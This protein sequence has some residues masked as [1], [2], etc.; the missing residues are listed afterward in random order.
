MPLIQKYSELLPWG[1]KITSESLRFFSP[2]VIWSIFEPTEQNHHVL[3]SALMDYYK[4]W[5]ELADQAIKEND[6]SKI[7]HNREAQHRYLTW[8]A[9]KD[10]G[11]PLLKKLIGE[12]HAKDLVTEFLFEGVNSLGSKSFL[13][14]FPEYAR[15]DGTVNKKRSMIGKSF[16]TRPWDAD[17]EFIGGDDAG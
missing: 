5:L 3:Y 16:E 13:D 4:V 2:V 8:R 1:G 12:S 9:E 10:P 6:A 14:Y 17:G 15:D 11:Y 7:A